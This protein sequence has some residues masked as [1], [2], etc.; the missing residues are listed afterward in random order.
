MYVLCRSVQ[1][2]RP[3]ST[4]LKKSWGCAHPEPWNE[5]SSFVV[6]STGC[7]SFN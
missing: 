5:V 1:A 7:S 3:T 2:H 4:P 6:V